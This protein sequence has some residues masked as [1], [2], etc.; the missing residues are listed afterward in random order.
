MDDYFTFQSAQCL[1]VFCCNGMEDW[2][3]I[4]F[5]LNPEGYN[6]T[7]LTFLEK[8][9]R[10][11]TY[12]HVQFKTHESLA[13]PPLFHVQGRLGVKVG[14]HLRPGDGRMVVENVRVMAARFH[15]VNVIKAINKRI[16]PKIDERYRFNLY[17]QKAPGG[18][19]QSALA[20]VVGDNADFLTGS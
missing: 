10:Y 14:S 13:V 15:L 19:C 7:H 6:R 8:R 9:K 17:T 16:Q 4:D 2:N 12:I 20:P 5:R 3:S 18:K 1:L 11:V